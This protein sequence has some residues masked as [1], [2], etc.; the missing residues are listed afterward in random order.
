MKRF[1][2]TCCQYWVTAIIITLQMRFSCA[3]WLNQRPNNSYSLKKNL[4]AY[5]FFCGVMLFRARS[6]RY[7]VLESLDF[8][9]YICP[10]SFLHHSFII[11][12][13]LFYR[14]YTKHILPN[15]AGSSTGLNS[16]CLSYHYYIMIGDEISVH[17]AMAVWDITE[18]IYDVDVK[19]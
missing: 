15:P 10:D 17:I 3:I 6:I 1:N 9:I 16:L 8:L 14:F 12:E 2:N 19:I 11:A 18:T 5:H 4:N 13:L 7:S